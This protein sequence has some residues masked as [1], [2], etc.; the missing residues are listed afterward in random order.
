MATRGKLYYN[1]QEVFFD[2]PD[3]WN[4]LAQAEP[5][6]APGVADLKVEVKRALENPIGTKN[7]AE[8]IPSS[9]KVVLIS[10]DQTRP[11][12]V[13][14]V[15]E[16]LVEMLGEL[17][18]EDERIQVVIGR[19]THRE[20]TAEELKTKLGKNNLD[21]LEVS[22]HD[23]DDTDNLVLMGMTSRKTPV[24][25][26]RIVAEAGLRIGV[27]TMNPHY[28]AGYGGGA[29]LILP[30][31]SGR[32]T[33]AYNHAMVADEKA[34]QGIMDGNPIWEDMLEAA[35][36]AKLDM[37]IDLVLNTAKQVNKLFAGEV[38]QVQRAAVKALLEIY[39]LEVPKMADITLTSGYPLEVNLIQSGKAILLANEVTKDG[40]AIVLLA[41]LSDGAGPGMY[42]TLR[43][44]PEPEVIIQWIKEGKATPTA[45][46]LAAMA[47]ELLK[48]KRMIVVTDGMTKEQIEDMDMEYAS[49]VEEAIETLSGQF[50]NP[51]VIISPVGSSTFPYVAD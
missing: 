46:P 35:R 21:R 7:L 39:G 47:R 34:R 19:G 32:E 5:K 2:L 22:I 43:E 8:M 11:S 45:G 1:G 48:K 37:K 31:V 3:N 49:S 6:D 18:V 4:L 40:G 42:E 38:E 29:K 12:P 28:F 26:N 17:G 44:K 50:E 27:G 24:W 51:D 9:G 10:E 16:P 41:A 23:A 25:I 20:A 36:I 30:G 13:G 15:M 14:Q 33:I